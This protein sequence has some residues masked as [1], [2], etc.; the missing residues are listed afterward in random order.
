MSR[1]LAE[2][3]LTLKSAILSFCPSPPA[4]HAKFATL[5]ILP[6]ALE[7]TNS[8]SKDI[9]AS[10]L[11]LPRRQTCLI[12]RAASSVNRALLVEQSCDQLQ[13]SVLRVSSMMRNL[14]CSHRWGVVSRPAAPLLSMLHR[15]DHKIP[16]QYSASVVLASAPLWYG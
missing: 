6:I 7:Q 2:T 11:R 1:K 13:W 4:A 8:T 9:P 16:L 3:C 12:S 15:L 5:A 10:T 14:N